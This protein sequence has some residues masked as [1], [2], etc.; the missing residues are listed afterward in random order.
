MNTNEWN[1]IT[2]DGLNTSSMN[3]FKSKLNKYPR[4]ARFAPG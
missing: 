3:V 1:I 4:R 2:T